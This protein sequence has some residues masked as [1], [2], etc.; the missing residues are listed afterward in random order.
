MHC[1][2]VTPSDDNHINPGTHRA[3]LFKDTFTPYYGVKYT[4]NAGDRNS[5][6]FFTHAH[7]NKLGP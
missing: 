1:S 3:Y 4:E 7:T 5:G 6:E 2:M